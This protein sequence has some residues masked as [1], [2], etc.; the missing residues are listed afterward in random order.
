[1][2]EQRLPPQPEA[3][4]EFEGPLIPATTLAAFDDVVGRAVERVPRPFD[5]PITELRPRLQLVPDL[6]DQVAEVLRGNP[7]AAGRL[8]LTL[9][10]FG[11]AEVPMPIA[12]EVLG[13][14]LLE[15]GAKRGR[16][17]AKA[18]AA[19]P[20]ER[21]SPPRPRWD[22]L[23]ALQRLEALA[24]AAVYVSRDAGELAVMLGSLQL[25]LAGV[26][27]MQTLFDLSLV[28]AP[29]SSLAS[30]FETARR[31]I[32]PM[33]PHRGE[34]VSQDVPEGFVFEPLLRPPGGRGILGFPV[35]GLRWPGLVRRPEPVP[36]P[37]TP[38]R[39]LIVTEFFERCFV[40]RI[41]PELHRRGI[42]FRDLVTSS[43]GYYVVESVEPSDACP[44]EII[45]IEGSNFDGTTGVN[46]VD[47][48]GRTVAV[49]P[50]S[51]SSGRITVLLPEEARTGPVSLYIPVETR[52]CLMT[53]TMA[54]PGSPGEIRVGR[55]SILRFEVRHGLGCVT[56]GDSAAL[57]WSVLPEDAD[58]T[59]VRRIG[60]T[61]TVLDA[62]A[63]AAGELLLETTVVGIHEYRIE[64]SN[65]SGSCEGASR[66]V[67]LEVKRVSPTGIQIVG[68]ER[69]QGI[70]QFSLADPPPY[71]NNAVGL[72][73]NMDTILR[74]FVRT[75]HPAIGPLARVTGVLSFGGNTYM[76]I[77][78][79]S[80]FINASRTP[81]RDNTNDSLNFLIP[82]ADASGSGEATV[83]VFTTGSC[84]DAHETWSEVLTWLDRP[85]LPVTIRRI[86]DSGPA[87]NVLTE[88]QVVDIVT[89]AF[90]RI[91]SP[92]TE[93]RVQPGV[94]QIREGTTEDNYCS[95]GGFYQL[96]L[97][98]AY[99]HNDN[100]GYPPAPHR[101]SWVGIYWSIGCAVGGMMAWPSTSTCIS[102][103]VVE[104]VAHELM[105]TVGLGH[106]KTSAGEDCENVFQ[107]VAC[108]W[109]DHLIDGVL[110]HVPF[111]IANNGTVPFANDLQSYK[112]SPLWL[113]VA[114][115]TLGRNLM[116]TRY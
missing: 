48:R 17:Q 82:A 114:L 59:I 96:A 21:V 73:A 90:S 74:V 66:T 34:P 64:V 27:E 115:W 8:R 77:N 3:W 33:R 26:D 49:A 113:S 29:E 69:T 20:M 108:H 4:P 91:P 7:V 63:D 81:N 10:S 9:R 24:A 12:M 38:P 72:I 37:F 95:E 112:G 16:K 52:L 93:I 70:Q 30:A 76:P 41:I 40:T 106:T 15:G 51:V 42:G 98:I 87:P 116:D 2:N 58:V 56:R 22:Q 94:H 86:A 89:Q 11:G 28:G 47:D 5:T 71:P 6:L 78:A 44:G 104:T 75:T 109:Q 14:K 1:M 18:E 43:S 111:D 103:R 46:F 101:S 13:G 62:A 36:I 88:S 23:I 55:T 68:V 65:P 39:A 92:K 85:A 31:V 105:H 61:E 32:L 107:P 19:Q 102:S 99:E 80:P 60:T 83:E 25:G 67:T 45:T 57:I 54:L 35:P 100:E 110:N 50:A 79:P 84:A 97:S 53:H